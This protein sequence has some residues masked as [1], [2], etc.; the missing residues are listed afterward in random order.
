[1]KEAQ[2]REEEVQHPA[3]R[4]EYDAPRSAEQRKTELLQR[5]AEDAQEMEI[6]AELNRHTL[7]R[8]ERQK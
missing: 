7:L 1:M 8:G 3:M 4:V 2:Q 6:W 5:K